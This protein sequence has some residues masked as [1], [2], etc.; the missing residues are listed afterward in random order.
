MLDVLGQ[1]AA[2]Q[3]GAA[4]VGAGD[5]VEAA[6]A[7]M[8]LGSAGTVRG[9]WS[10]G[11]ALPPLLHPAGPYLEVFDEPAP[12]AALLAVDAAD[13]QAQHLRLQLRV[14][15][16][17]G[18]QRRGVSIPHRAAGGTR[19]PHPSL[20]GSHRHAARGRIP[21]TGKRTSA[22]CRERVS[23]PRPR[24]TKGSC[25]RTGARAR[26][27]RLCQAG[28]RSPGTAPW[29]GGTGDGD[30]PSERGTTSTCQAHLG[31]VQGQLVLGALEDAFAARHK[32]GVRLAR[33]WGTARHR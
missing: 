12:A 11:T 16:D 17:L 9:G 21:P 6:G 3:L 32:R 25:F 28:A 26:P 19:T 23:V 4:P 5:D 24:G 2:A 33:G 20:A 13:G 22:L 15:I 30:V 7:K 14:G 29:R 1:V 18:R 31:V 10:W 8:G 27:A